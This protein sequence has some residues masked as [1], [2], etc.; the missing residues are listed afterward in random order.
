MELSQ[1]ASVSL[2][3]RSALAWG[4]GRET[5]PLCGPRQCRLLLLVQE[6]VA[7]IPVPGQEGIE[8]D[9]GRNTILKSFH[10]GGDDPAGIGMAD[11]RDVA[12]IFPKEDVH[13]IIDVGLSALIRCD[14]SPRPV[15]VG[16]KTR[17]PCLIRRSATRRHT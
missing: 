14:R 2:W 11:E 16:V 4:Q 1:A 8:I 17:W 3:I 12:Q 7:A 5:S 15:S 6:M 13:H 10:S 9:H